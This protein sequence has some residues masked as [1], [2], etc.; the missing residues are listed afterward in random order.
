MRFLSILAAGCVL[1]GG[2]VSAARA[3]TGV[4]VQMFLAEGYEIK[5]AAPTDEGGYALFLQRDFGAVECIVSAEGATRSCVALSAPA[6]SI[7]MRGKLRG[8]VIGF[9]NR[10]GCFIPGD[11]VTR[12]LSRTY[13][14]ALGYSRSAVSDMVAQLQDEGVLISERG[15]LRLVVGC[16]Q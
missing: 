16:L 12:E 4:E 9:F 15:G 5:A 7:I 6:Q 1:L 13:F 2:A 10:Y 14:E 11:S 3:E 8:E